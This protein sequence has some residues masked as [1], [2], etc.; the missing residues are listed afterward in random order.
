MLYHLD[1]T[2]EYAAAMRQRDLF[3]IW[4]KEAEAALGAKQAGVVVDLWKCVGQRRVI[5]VVNVDSPDMLD[6][7]TLDL[8]IMVEMGQHVQIAVTPLRRYED[9]ASDVKKRLE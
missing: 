3:A 7:I 2:V 5:A 8:P 1:F 4:A 6:Q 9:F